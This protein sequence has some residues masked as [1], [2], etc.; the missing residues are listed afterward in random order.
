MSP[1]PMVPAVD[2]FRDRLAA[3]A[4]DVGNW[5]CIGLDPDPERYPADLSADDTLDYCLGVVE[6]TCD[7]ACA[8]KP[9]AAFF[10]ALGT[11]GHEV[12]AA[13][14][15]TIPN[16]IPVILDGKRNDI[17][18]TARKYAVAAFDELGADAVTVTP[19]LG[20]DSVA[21][22]TAYPDKGV[23]LLTRTSNPS[24][25]DLQDLDVGGR[26]LWHAVAE[27]A[28][29]WQQE[30]ANIGLVAGATHPEE[31]ATIRR[32]CSDDVPLLV[33]GVGAQG[34]DA[35]AA[36]DAGADRSGRFALVNVGRAI[37]Y[38]DASDG[39][40]WTQDVRAAAQGFARQLAP[41]TA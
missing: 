1:G 11:L 29:E 24:A 6:S 10:E 21:P 7:L 8:Y 17:G 36:L 40:D 14:I 3:R 30:F 9:N 4:A 12:L 13:T 37:L 33:P 26:P 18:N 19:Y 2:P 15:A 23:F 38:P 34:A 41:R 22:F 35:A 25:G 28:M 5:L 39:D 27:K 16:E 32:L 31:L 20:R